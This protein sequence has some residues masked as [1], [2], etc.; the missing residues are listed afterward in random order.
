M[1]IG[2]L[3]R[4]ERLRRRLTQEELAEA[5]GVSAKSVRRWEKDIVTPTA[6]YRLRLSK[7]FDIFPEKFFDE[8]EEKQEAQ[9]DGAP[10][11][12]VPQKQIVH[13][14]YRRNPLFTGRETVLRQLHESLSNSPQALSGLGGIGKTQ[15]A[16]E[17]AYRYAYEYQT[18]FWVRAETR[19]A[20]LAGLAVYAHQRSLPVKYEQDSYRVA[21]MV[22]QWLTQQQ[23]WLLVFDNMEHLDLVASLLPFNHQGHIL[24]TTRLQAIGS[25]GQ[26][27]HME[28]MEQEEG[29]LLL[30]RRAKLLPLSLS[31]LSQIPESIRT[32]ALGLYTRLGGLP[33]ALDQAG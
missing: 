8:S 19:E 25:L 3:I 2:K 16:L 28:C 32:T 1:S 20:L 12:A 33:L 5:L 18:I 7:F 26:C 13:L 11:K 23:R 17:Y 10:S 4:Q 31:S 29:V 24:L 14:P 22:I 21:K 9:Q 27:I 15:T 30:L 6:H